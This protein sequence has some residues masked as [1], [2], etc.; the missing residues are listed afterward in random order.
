MGLTELDQPIWDFCRGKRV[1]YM[2]GR[3]KRKK[4]EKEKV[5]GHRDDRKNKYWDNDK[6]IKI[7]NETNLEKWGGG[8]KIERE[9]NF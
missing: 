8:R 5:R 1:P 7:T 3:W 6:L 4:E 9:K 2:N